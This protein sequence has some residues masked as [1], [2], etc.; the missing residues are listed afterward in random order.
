MPVPRRSPTELRGS[1]RMRGPVNYQ[2]RAKPYEA[3][4]L[5]SVAAH[6]RLPSRLR[7]DLARVAPDSE[8]PDRLRPLEEGR[9]GRDRRASAPLPLSPGPY[10]PRAMPQLGLRSPRFLRVMLAPRTCAQVVTAASARRLHWTFFAGAAR[11][12]RDALRTPGSKPLSPRRG[13]APEC[14]SCF[15]M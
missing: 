10:W 2:V 9:R 12:W 15:S 13:T 5:C 1:L 11:C 14:V 6:V 4:L 8:I 3:L 7:R